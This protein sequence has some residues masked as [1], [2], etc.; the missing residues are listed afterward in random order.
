[1][2]WNFLIKSNNTS[3]KLLLIN[4]IYVYQTLPR[5]AGHFVVS[6]YGIDYFYQHRISIP[7]K[8]LRLHLPLYVIFA[9]NLEG[10]YYY[11][12]FLSI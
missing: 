2:I 4:F 11:A 10:M 6:R 5:F 1:M 3:F 9:S 7:M 12:R 8:Q